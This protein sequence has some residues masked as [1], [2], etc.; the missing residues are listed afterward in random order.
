MTTDVTRPSSPGSDAGDAAVSPRARLA[1]RAL[2]LVLAALAFGQVAGFE[3][4]YDDDWTLVH[5]PHLRRSLAALASELL[6]GHRNAAA[7]PDATRPSMVLSTALDVRAFGHWPGGYHLHSLALYLCIC[8]FAHA[9]LRRL[10]VHR[11][12]ALAGALFFALAPVHAEAVAAINYREDLILTLGVLGLSLW[13]LRPG[14]G[15]ETTTSTALVA[16]ATAVTLGAK[17]SGIVLLPFLGAL[18]ALRGGLVATLQRREPAF[19]AIFITTLAWG[20]WRT[21]MANAGA[22]I[23]VRDYGGALSQLAHTARYIVLALGHGLLPWSWSPEYDRVATAGPLWFAALAA[24]GAATAA[25]WRH[26]PTRAMGYG[27]LIVVGCLLPTSPLSAP[28]NPY[29][30]RYLCLGLFGAALFWSH[31]LQLAARAMAR[32]SLP[33]AAAAALALVF[34]P[35][36]ATAASAWRDDLTLWRTATSRAPGSARAWQGL[37]RAQRLRGHTAEARAS[38]IRALMLDPHYG[39]A[40]VTRVYVLAAAGAVPAARSA[41][42]KLSDRERRLPGVARAKRCLARSDR[43]VAACL[44]K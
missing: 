3:F 31:A 44:A 23:P 34:T 39:P 29:A 11:R 21:S 17:E 38:V 22:D 41:L 43:E 6:G 19:S 25:L 9:L 35:L 14:P 10:G 2:P 24:V 7:I 40:R 42:A 33:L 1:Y 28:I 4:T 26:R 32:P 27:V 12:A 36:G 37:S 5:N 18:L 15:R 16:T 13:V 8:G 30:D 20:A